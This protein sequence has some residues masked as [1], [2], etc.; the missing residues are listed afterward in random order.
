MATTKFSQTP[1]YKSDSKSEASEMLAKFKFSPAAKIML[2]KQCEKGYFIAS[3]GDVAKAFGRHV[4][5][6][7]P[8]EKGVYTVRFGETR[9]KKNLSITAA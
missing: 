3:H 6:T 7:N 2:S 1:K 8:D 5:P 9:L 4:M